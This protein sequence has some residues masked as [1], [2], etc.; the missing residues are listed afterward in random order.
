VEGH[1]HAIRQKDK[2]KPKRNNSLWVAETLGIKL[3]IIDI[4]E[5]LMTKAPLN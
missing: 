4:I 5:D 1:T 2:D 3:H